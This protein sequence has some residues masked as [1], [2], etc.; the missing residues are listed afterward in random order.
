MTTEIPSVMTG[1]GLCQ[2]GDPCE[3]HVMKVNPWYSGV[4]G[5]TSEGSVNPPKEVWGQSQLMEIAGKVSVVKD[6][7][8]YWELDSIGKITM[9]L[10]TVNRYWHEHGET[11]NDLHQAWMQWMDQAKAKQTY[12]AGGW[13]A[14]PQQFSQFVETIK[15]LQELRLPLSPYLRIGTASGKH[16][17][18]EIF[19]LG[20]AGLTKPQ[21]TVVDICAPPLI[22]TKVVAKNSIAE[23]QQRSILEFPPEGHTNFAVSTAH[24]TE[25][26]IPTN[27]QYD[28]HQMNHN[29]ALQ[30]K[31]TFVLHVHTLLQQNGV[32][33]TCL[34]TSGQ[35][36]R[37]NTILEVSDAFI[38]A[39]FK[40]K[41]LIMVPTTDPFDYESGSYLPGNYFVVAMK[42]GDD[43]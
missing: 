6:H 36:R 14:S 39:G 16:T 17:Q 9:V 26:F 20:L 13:A 7:T 31:Y 32:F 38:K 4:P 42:E 35:A 33:I 22:E 3:Y 10:N 29:Q 8:D 12:G 40:G 24:Y 11:H 18:Q 27:E 21:L 25:S 34:G 37:F 30:I 28:A 2:I 19:G 23:V 5:E 15:V 41:N 1:S 43:I